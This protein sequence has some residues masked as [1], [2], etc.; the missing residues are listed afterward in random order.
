MLEGYLSFSNFNHYNRKGLHD[1]SVAQK[2]MGIDVTNKY[3]LLDC[4]W[5]CILSLN[6]CHRLEL[7][8]FR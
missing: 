3:M 4:R 5:C 8:P 7:S 6:V 1:V 2:P